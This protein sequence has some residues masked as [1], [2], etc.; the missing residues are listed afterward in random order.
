MDRNKLQSEL[1]GILEDFNLD[2]DYI[3]DDDEDWDDE[4]YD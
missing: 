3:E 2:N 4:E 1:Q